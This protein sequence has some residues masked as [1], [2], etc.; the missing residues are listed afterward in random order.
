[1]APIVLAVTGL[2]HAID[3]EGLARMTGLGL[4]ESADGTLTLTHRGRLLA[5]DVVSSV[6]A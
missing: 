4:I 3:P 5:N 2:E 1:M 6:I